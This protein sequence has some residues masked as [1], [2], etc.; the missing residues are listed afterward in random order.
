M[1][2]E[3]LGLIKPILQSL[4]AEGYENPTPIQE[5][6]RRLILNEEKIYRARE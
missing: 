4:S 6:S 1:T 3:Q 2:F 5:K